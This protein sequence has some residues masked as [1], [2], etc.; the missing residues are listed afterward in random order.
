[1]PTSFFEENQSVRTA[2]QTLSAIQQD[3]M[4]SQEQK[5]TEQNRILQTEL[6]RE[7]QFA[8][9]EGSYQQARSYSALLLNVLPPLPKNAAAD[10]GST[11]EAHLGRKERKKQKK[12]Q[13][14]AYKELDKSQRLLDYNDI[15]NL[16]Q[17]Q[18][19]ESREKWADAKLKHSSLTRGETIKMVSN[20]DY[21]NFENLDNV[22]RNMFAKE[23]LGRM[24]EKYDLNHPQQMETHTPEEIC[25]RIQQE[26][27]VSALLDPTLRL[28]LSLTQKQNGIYNDSQKEW[29][30]KL[31]EQMSAAVM[32][33]TLTHTTDHAALKETVKTNGRKRPLSDEKADKKAA[34]MIAAGKAQQ[35]QTAKRLL[36]MHLGRFTRV[37]SNGQSS[38]WDKPTAVALSHC[39]RVTLT[40][41]M[42]TSD[43][44]EAKA[45]YKKMWNSIFYQKDKSNPAH[46]ERRGSSTHDLAVKKRDAAVKEKKVLFNFRSQRGM[47]VAI[48]GLGNNGIS[49]RTI[50]NDGSCGHFYSMYKEGDTSHY[51]AMLMGMESDSY[52]V[53]NQLGHTHDIK[54]TGEKASSLGGQRTDEVGAKYGGR[55]C[56][57]SGLTPE[58][59]TGYM[60]KLED[61]MKNW[62]K[63]E[64]GLSSGDGAFVMEKLVGTPMS[65]E[66][67]ADVLARLERAAA[68]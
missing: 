14:K 20:G 9:Q 47:N 46:D 60:E 63:T 29:F 50:L 44:K 8:R 64:N 59:I 54:A 37:D 27:G 43:T 17:F 49:G 52:G 13:E 10:Q 41:P 58:Q 15:K 30:R 33:E 45:A 56:D 11:P 55:R 66:L 4:L 12:M 31:D 40:L 68:Q 19:K 7:R 61:A 48:G 36:L 28:G 21:S 38:D 53:K 22:M 32:L 18:T 1:M 23:S 62:Q 67:L 35:I 25:T 34:D 16:P 26:G 3:K 42:Q 51:G 65:A 39:S 6:E 5:E 57:L 24:L 2:E